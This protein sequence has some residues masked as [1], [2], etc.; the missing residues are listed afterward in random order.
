MIDIFDDIKKNIEK[1]IVRY[2]VANG[3]ITTTENKKQMVGVTIDATTD[4]T[5]QR[6]AGVT[7]HLADS[8]QGKWA[9]D[10]RKKLEVCHK[11]LD[12]F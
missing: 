1:M 6:I 2:T 4:T 11:E 12:N 8:F 5:S 7:S 10:V 3:A 9:G